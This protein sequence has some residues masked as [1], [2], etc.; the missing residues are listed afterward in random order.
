MLKMQL[1]SQVLGLFYM[2]VKV[3]QNCCR[4]LGE[5]MKGGR[6]CKGIQKKQKEIIKY[7]TGKRKDYIVSF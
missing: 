3:R 7:A 6:R 2:W 5:Q 4:Q 1:R